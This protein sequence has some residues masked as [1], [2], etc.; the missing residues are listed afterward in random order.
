[1]REAWQELGPE[2]MSECDEEPVSVWD[3]ESRGSDSH[4][5][6][7]ETN[8]TIMSG[9]SESGSDCDVLESPMKRRCANRDPGGGGG[10]VDLHD[11]E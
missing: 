7:E 5:S 6:S 10:Q 2:E 3:V 11:M 4:S 1:M 8:E 9:D